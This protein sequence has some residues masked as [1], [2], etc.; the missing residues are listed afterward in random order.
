[1]LLIKW[2][3]KSP[4]TIKQ[5]QEQERARRV[6][7]LKTS[8]WV[9]IATISML[10]LVS[11]VLMVLFMCLSNNFR[12]MFMSISVNPTNARFHAKMLKILLIATMIFLFLLNCAFDKLDELL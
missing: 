8:F 2:K 11:I 4:E 6:K 5:E 10:G 7:Q 9:V 1:M 3:P 12:I